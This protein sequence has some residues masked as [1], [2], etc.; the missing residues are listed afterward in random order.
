[1]IHYPSKRLYCKVSEVSHSTGGFKE[2]FPFT[3]GS[4]AHAGVSSSLIHGASSASEARVCSS[5]NIPHHGGGG[6]RT[7]NGGTTALPPLQI[8]LYI[9]KKE[10]ISGNWE[11]LLEMEIVEASEDFQSTPLGWAEGGQVPQRGFP[12][13]MEPGS[14]RSSPHL[15]VPDCPVSATL[16]TLWAKV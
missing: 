11:G 9:E 1:M 16:Q 7:T 3:L 13:S 14:G 8:C 12:P 5:L 10:M 4:L 15:L 6:T 2:D